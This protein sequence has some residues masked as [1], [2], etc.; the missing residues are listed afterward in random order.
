MLSSLQFQIFCNSFLKRY[1]KLTKSL[2]SKI[3]GLQ[4]F[5]CEHLLPQVSFFTHFDF[6]SSGLQ[7]FF[8]IGILKDFAVFTGKH[9]CWSLFLIKL[10]EIRDE[11]CSK[12]LA[13]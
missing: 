4:V 13:H 9:L 8:K 12:K 7:M 1:A 2:F 5:S 11:T 10:V 6:R 3:A